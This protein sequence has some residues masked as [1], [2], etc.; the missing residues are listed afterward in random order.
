MRT[1]LIIIIWAC[2]LAFVPSGHAQASIQAQLSHDYRF[3]SYVAFEAIL[4]AQVIPKEAR[5][6]FIAQGENSTRTGQAN[7]NRNVLS[8]R[9]ELAEQPLRAFVDIDYWFEFEAPDGQNLSTQIGKFRY[10]DDR[11]SWQER[12]NGQIRLK[13]YEGDTQFAQAVIDTAQT[14][15]ANIQTILPLPLEQ[16]VEIYSYASAQEMRDTLQSFSRN[17][18]GAH[19]DPDLGV[20]VISLPQGP[21]QRLEMER[22]VPHELMHILL[23]RH[24]GNGYANLPAW[25]NEGLAS[26]A[27]LYPNPDYIVLIERALQKGSL[28]PMA[29]LCATFPRD[30]SGTFLAYAQSASFT[31]FLVDEFGTSG[32]EK[33][34]QAYANGLGC[35]QGVQS[36]TSNSMTELERRWRQT[37]FGENA[38]LSGLEKLLPYVGLVLAVVIIPL[39]IGLARPAN[40]SPQSPSASGSSSGIR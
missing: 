7:V 12:M 38:W 35:E 11:Y 22:Q 25:L 5:L 4:P 26:L 8:Y 3:G 31:R 33:L 1:T 13:W 28:L 36:A 17:W 18:V 32:M 20:M 19:A 14:G 15:Y 29:S 24:L 9:L 34:L 23:Y 10:L 6:F 39:L 27:E 30:A 16:P 21:E 40:K 37:Y 2:L